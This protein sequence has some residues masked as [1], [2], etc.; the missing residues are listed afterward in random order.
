VNLSNNF[1][2]STD[3]ISGGFSVLDTASGKAA[4]FAGSDIL[5]KALSE[6][7][8]VTNVKTNNIMTTNM[9]AVPLSVSTQSTYLQSVSVAQTS[10]VGTTSSLNPGTVTTGTNITILPKVTSDNSKVMLT[11]VMDLSTLKQIRQI[12]SPDNTSKLEAP[13]IDSNAINQRVWLKPN[14]TLIISG[15]EQDEKSGTK[16]G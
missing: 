13:N 6:Q 15:F 4:Q 14:D 16:Q 10:N 5:F 7:V 2:N 11:M 3:A 12:N 8:N 1:T 9:A